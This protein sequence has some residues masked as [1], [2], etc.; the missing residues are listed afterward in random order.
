[1]PAVKEPCKW[2]MLRNKETII[3]FGKYDLK[4][5]HRLPFCQWLITL[6]MAS[7]VNFYQTFKEKVASHFKNFQKIEEEVI[8]HTSFSESNLTLIWKAFYLLWFHLFL[9]RSSGDWHHAVM[10]LLVWKGRQA[11]GLCSIIYSPGYLIVNGK[12]E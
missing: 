7:W 8:T 10:C 4:T 12:G 6:Q 9:N 1:M 3:F 11:I 5:G 2:T